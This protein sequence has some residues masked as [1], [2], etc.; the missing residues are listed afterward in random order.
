MENIDSV[1]V[2]FATEYTKIENIKLAKKEHKDYQAI[3]V[4]AH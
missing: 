3:T 1:T 4:C 2:N